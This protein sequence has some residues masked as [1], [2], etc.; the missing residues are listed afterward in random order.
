MSALTQAPYDP[1]LL[2]Q[3]LEGKGSYTCG[4]NLLWIDLLVSITPNV[5]VNEAS[6][7]KGMDKYFPSPDINWEL[8]KVVIGVLPA[9]L[10]VLAEGKTAPTGLR[11]LSP[12]EYLHSFVLKVAD[13]V[14]AAAS[15]G[16]LKSWANLMLS[17]PV[18]FQLAASQ[19][20]L[21]FSGISIRENYGT[22]FDLLF[23]STVQR[24]YELAIYR[25]SQT[26]K[27]TYKEVAQKWKS[28]V[29][30]ST[31]TE[32]GDAKDWSSFVEVALSVYDRCLKHPVVQRLILD[33]EEKWG[34]QTPW[35]S[36]YKLE[37]LVSKC[38]KPSGRADTAGPLDRM[39]WVIRCVH[40]FL[41]SEQL[42]RTAL[43]VRNLSGKGLFGHKGTAD[44]LVYKYGLGVYIKDYLEGSVLDAT[45]KAEIRKVFRDHE[46]YRA[47][48]GSPGHMAEHDLSWMG[49]LCKPART[50]CSVLKQLVYTTEYDAKIKRM[51]T[52]GALVA[53]WLDHE[54][55]QELVGPLKTELLGHSNAEK[56]NAAEEEVKAVASPQQQMQDSIVNTLK[57]TADGSGNNGSTESLVR[58]LPETD[59]VRVMDS[60]SEAKRYVRQFIKLFVDDERTEGVMAVLN[61]SVLSR[62]AKSEFLMVN[63]DVKNSGE[64][65]TAPHIRVAPLKVDLLRRCIQRTC[66]FMDSPDAMPENV[67]FTVFDGGKTG[68]QTQIMN[69]FAASDKSSMPK[70]V[71][72]LH[73]CYEENSVIARMERYRA[74]TSLQQLE[75]V[76]IAARLCFLVKNQ[77][78]VCTRTIE[79][80]VC[81]EQ[82]FTTAGS[83]PLERRSAATGPTMPERPTGK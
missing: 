44:L 68:N 43:S 54:E 12:E 66:K 4:A 80:A 14:R 63:Y 61:E 73:L 60:I 65:V 13:R 31:I 48:F 58:S 82:R 28:S 46:T 25:D 56:T 67:L 75:I 81:I 20:K 62:M 10:D 50:A 17:L 37:T 18:T 47:A 36:V 53:D 1:Q 38:G 21:Y 16:E 51:M 42:Q 49:A 59:L 35:D 11:L 27:M 70:T 30:F 41:D 55:L 15:M 9:Q 2:K 78:H 26:A 6:I 39:A 5:P 32:E 79:A 77:R 34:K 8:G 64:P 29:T 74:N 57:R 19:E 24:I 23:R 69:Q 33:A 7:Q 72:S 40:D 76:H 3:A 22:G 45:Q 71:R 83:F 52:S